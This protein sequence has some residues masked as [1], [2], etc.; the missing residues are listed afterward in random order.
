MTHAFSESAHGYLQTMI[1]QMTHPSLYLVIQSCVLFTLFLMEFEIKLDLQARLNQTPSSMM[2][3][4][5][6][7]GETNQSLALLC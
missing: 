1:Q 7:D 2:I 6:K 3:C 4:S 5:D